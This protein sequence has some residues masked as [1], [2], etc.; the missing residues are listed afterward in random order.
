MSGAG[1][2]SP[3]RRSDNVS[4]SSGPTAY[5]GNALHGAG[6]DVCV[7]STAVKP[8]T[9]TCRSEGR[10][11]KAHTSAASVHGPSGAGRPS[12]VT[13]PGLRAVSSTVHAP[14]RTCRRSRPSGSRRA[15]NPLDSDIGTKP[16]GSARPRSTSR[17]RPDTFRLRCVVRRSGISSVTRRYTS[18]STRSLSS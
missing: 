1:S 2:L 5:A 10:A 16:S 11:S 14:G 9:S 13:G 12:D 3:R 6:S 4:V 18:S 17:L 15:G 7:G 8:S